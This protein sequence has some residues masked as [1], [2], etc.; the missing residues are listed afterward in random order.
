MIS[1]ILNNVLIVGE[2][3]NYGREVSKDDIKERLYLPYDKYELKE[4]SILTQSFSNYTNNVRKIKQSSKGTIFLKGKINISSVQNEK[5]KS[6][7]DAKSKKSKATSTVTKRSKAVSKNQK[8]KEDPEYPFNIFKD[9]FLSFFKKVPD[10]K[11]RV[12]ILRCLNLSAQKD[13]IEAGHFLAGFEGKCSANSYPEILVGKGEN[14]GDIIKCVNDSTRSIDHDLNPKYFRMFELD[15]TLP[16]DWRLEIRIW[17]K[18]FIKDTLI[19]SVEIDLEDRLWGQP[20]LK[21]RMTYQIYKEHFEKKINK[22]KYNFE[23]NTEKDKD[24]YRKK[25]SDIIGKIEIIDKDFKVPVE[26]LPL[27][28][29]DKNTSQGIIELFIEPFPVEVGQKLIYKNNL[30]NNIY[31]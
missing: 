24:K 29:T 12:Y 3:Y 4:C 7:K 30:L 1:K 18:E 9:K 13:H 23:Q 21:K 27:K 28:N 11:T 22:L 15:A 20:E 26:Y 17:N 25:L 31:S 14:I 5:E 8:Y 10:L 2:D 16:E 6:N 19:G